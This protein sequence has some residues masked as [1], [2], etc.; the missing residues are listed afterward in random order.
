MSPLFSLNPV[1]SAINGSSDRPA[2][3]CAAVI[4]ASCGTLQQQGYMSAASCLPALQHRG[5]HLCFLLLQELLTDTKGLALNIDAQKSASKVTNVER[6][7]SVCIPQIMYSYANS[8]WFSHAHLILKQKAIFDTSQSLKPQIRMWKFRNH[9]KT[10]LK[11]N[12][13]FPLGKVPSSKWV[14][15]SFPSF[16]K[17][18]SWCSLIPIFCNLQLVQIKIAPTESQGIVL[19]VL[20]RGTAL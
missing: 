14:T 7:E 6:K 8:M 5:K 18:F 15:A 17:E 19:F 2:V 20:T 9:Q 3:L 13:I 12:Y 10:P 16:Y 11:C 1:Y 4:R